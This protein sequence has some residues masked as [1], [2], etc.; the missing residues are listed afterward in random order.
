MSFL[1][2]LFGKKKSKR[3]RPT[4]APRPVVRHR[5]EFPLGDNIVSDAE[6]R[7]F[8]DLGRHYPLPSGYEYQEGADGVPLIVREQDGKKFSFLI[9]AGMLTFDE[10]YMRDG[11]TKYKT[12]E[13]IKRGL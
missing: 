3:E 4:S 6:I 12:I 10:A 13:V 2:G 9:E 7:T 8:A 1:K 5:P 11:R